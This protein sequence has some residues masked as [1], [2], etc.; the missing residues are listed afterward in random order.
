MGNLKFKGEA[1]EFIP[2]ESPSDKE[3]YEHLKHLD[4]TLRHIIGEAF[5]IPAE[6]L[7]KES[8]HAIYQKTVQLVKEDPTI[9]AIVA[10][11]TIRH[12]LGEFLRDQGRSPATSADQNGAH[13]PG[14]PAKPNSP[15]V[16]GGTSDPRSDPRRTFGPDDPAD[17]D[18]CGG[19]CAP[20]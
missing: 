18:Y 5:R 4:T 14:E 1:P 17:D 19:Y 16:G 2:L 8:K 13:E 10:G 7:S 9:T 6:A 3:F 20:I 12:S 15:V 11:D